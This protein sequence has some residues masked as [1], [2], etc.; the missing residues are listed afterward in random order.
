MEYPKIGNR[1]AK[2]QCQK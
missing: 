1:C 2:K